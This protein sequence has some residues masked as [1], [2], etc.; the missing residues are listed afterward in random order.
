MVV[1]NQIGGLGFLSLRLRLVPGKFEGKCEGKKIKRK[2]KRK[3]KVKEKINK[4]EVNKLFVST[5]NFFDLFNS[6]I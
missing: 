1:Y 4:L 2:S 3:E 5:T 6:F